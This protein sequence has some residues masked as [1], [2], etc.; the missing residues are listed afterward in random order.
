M[1]TPF[2]LL[3]KSTII[4]SLC[5]FIF[6]FK[7][8]T[9]KKIIKRNYNSYYISIHKADSLY[10]KADFVNSY[11]LLKK[12]FTKYKPLNTSKY[13][14]YYTY[15]KL[16][17]LNNK[18]FKRKLKKA[19]KN[20]GLDMEGISSD[21][22]FL[23]AYKNSGMCDEDVKTL[24]KKYVKKIDLKLRTK[25]INLEIENYY[26]E[27]EPNK[28]NVDERIKSQELANKDFITS[29][30][31]KKIYPNINVI[32]GKSI[33]KMKVDIISL[34]LKTDLEYIIEKL[35]TLK[36]FVQRGKCPPENYALLV[37]YTNL[38]SNKEQ[39]YGVYLSDT[40][41][42]SNLKLKQYNIARN[43][44]GIPILNN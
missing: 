39:V 30:F 6:S 15:T 35:P 21:D 14:E 3:M 2:K 22:I 41:S 11:K 44:I 16:A 27:K 29:L 13:Q 33:D 23:K 31:N 37:D 17:Y 36:K 34:L 5:F 32:G 26:S 1:N 10:K 38:M 20:F 19:I 42:L 24:Y 18:K 12:T 40:L 28:N 7:S 4:I 8:A 43:S 25:I 9:N